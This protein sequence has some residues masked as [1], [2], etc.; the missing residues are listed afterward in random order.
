MKPI[1][2]DQRGTTT[3]EFG[4]IA[5]PFF[6][7]MFGIFDLGR[8]AITMHSLDTLA[9]MSARQVM[10][11]CYWPDVVF[12][13]T[14]P[15]TCNSDPYTD[16]QKQ[17]IAPF[18]YVGGLTPTVLPVTGAKILTVTA[19]QPGF[20]MLLPVWGTT[21]NAPSYSVTIPF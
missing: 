18:L 8:Y 7:L 19:R 5:M 1:R 12:N 4:L 2:R 14:S 16:A 6:W 13:N 3:L 17:A 15:S 11:T 9:S 20:T 10:I 21:L